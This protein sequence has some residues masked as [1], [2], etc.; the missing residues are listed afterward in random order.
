MR[1]KKGEYVRFADTPKEVPYSHRKTVLFSLLL[2]SL[3]VMVVMGIG[4]QSSRQTQRAALA[5]E[6]VARMGTN[7]DV[8]R[9]IGK[10]MTLRTGLQGEIK[11]DETGWKEAHLTIPVRGPNGDAT[12]HVI[13]GRRTG[14]WVFT[15]FEIDFEKQ[16]EKL[17]LISGRLVEYDPN[18][19]VEVHTQT[20]A[21]PQYSNTV[22]AAPRFDGEFP[23]VSATVATRSVVPQLG[24]CAMPTVHA[25]PVDRFEADLRY[26]RFVLR[27]TDLY[28][29]DVFKVPLTRSYSS[30]D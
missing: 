20:A 22:A 11:Q 8:V 17:N 10:P 16:H 28:L 25:G 26:G 4:V 6:A 15:T 9:I 2:A 13:G 27:E 24:N 5:K 18:A 21:L 29:D 7:A 3:L 1:R 30:S 23:C 14:P 19:Y 12:A